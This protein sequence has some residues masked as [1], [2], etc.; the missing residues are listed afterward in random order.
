MKCPRCKKRFTYLHTDEPLPEGNEKKRVSIYC[1]DCGYIGSIVIK[2]TEKL[3]TRLIEC[4]DC[5]KDVQYWIKARCHECHYKHL[6]K[7]YRRD[8]PKDVR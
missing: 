2:V 8:N 6:Q 7:I 3:N 1:P 5:G 4:V